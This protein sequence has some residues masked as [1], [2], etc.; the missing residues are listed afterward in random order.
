MAINGGGGTA[1]L[2]PKSQMGES[3]NML[4]KVNCFVRDAVAKTA[5][6]SHVEGSEYTSTRHLDN[7]RQ[8]MM[9]NMDENLQDSSRIMYHEDLP[10]DSQRNNILRE[11]LYKREQK[12]RQ[13]LDGQRAA[14][15]EDQ[16]GLRFQVHLN[17]RREKILRIDGYSENAPM[18]GAI[19]ES[20]HKD[21]QPMYINLYRLHRDQV[22]GEEPQQLDHDR[23]LHH[24]NESI[25]LVS[26]NR[27]DMNNYLTQNPLTKVISKFPLKLTAQ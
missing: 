23:H 24:H 13:E 27:D 26:T 3:S 10:Q 18:G 5:N 17:K 7:L 22:L 21:P 25:D 15:D 4:S 9:Q 11:P 12:F 6:G 16:F 20:N 2:T 1:P 19:S 14:L 8:E